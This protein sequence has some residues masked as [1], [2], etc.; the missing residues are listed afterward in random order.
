MIT[1]ISFTCSIDGLKDIEFPKYEKFTLKV[2][3]KE[4]EYDFLLHLTNSNKVIL[5]GAAG[6]DT[7]K[8]VPPIFHRNTWMKDFDQ[9]TICYNDPTLKPG[10]SL[11]WGMG[12]DDNW[13]MEDL[14]KIIK[15]ITVMIGIKNEDMLF[16]GYSAGA[17]QSFILSTFLK[18]SRVFSIN[19][20]IE[21]KKFTYGS[22]LRKENFRKAL[23][24]SFSCYEDLGEEET[25]NKYKERTNLLNLFDKYEYFPKTY[26]L[27]NI[28]YKPDVTNHLYDLI[29]HLGEKDYYE[30]DSLNIM[31][32][33]SKKLG[34]DPPPKKTIMKF[35][36]Q[37][38]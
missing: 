1:D 35:L 19:S 31:F 30:D 15:V 8:H 18:G 25:I 7:K 16:V 22:S 6:Y 11:G 28:S 3:H 4:V 38:I 23:K 26:Y 29:N 33:S 2:I 27:I 20:Q 37:I 36:N 14:S 34:H 5:F 12:K 13:Y 24:N 21:L 9:N 17:Y 32:Y 10:I